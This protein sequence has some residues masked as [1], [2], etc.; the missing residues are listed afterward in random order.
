[1]SPR[2]DLATRRNRLTQQAQGSAQELGS[3]RM[4]IY[5][6][7]G[8]KNGLV[9]APGADDVISQVRRGRR[10]RRQAG[11]CADASPRDAVMCATVGTQA[12]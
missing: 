1:V 10:W 7:R 11:T 4:S 2:S 12:V 8:S 3:R 9:N 5:T 6:A